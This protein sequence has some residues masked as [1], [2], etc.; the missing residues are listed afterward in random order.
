MTTENNITKKDVEHV[1]TLAKL[2]FNDEQLEKFT[3]QIEDIID[4]VDT[5]NEVDTTNV[6]PTFNV[7]DQLNRMREDVAVRSNDKEALLANAPETENGFIR[8]PAI[9]DESGE[10]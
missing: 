7:T 6:E 1:A 8:V 9:L 2:K 5:L 10:A 3:D 4:L